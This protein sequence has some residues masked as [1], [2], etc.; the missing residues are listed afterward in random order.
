MIQIVHVH[1]LII[2]NTLLYVLYL[3]CLRSESYAYILHNSNTKNFF[4]ILD[5]RN[6]II[7]KKKIFIYVINRKR[8]IRFSINEYFYEIINN[9]NIFTRK[10][11]LRVQFSE[12]L[13]L[14]YILKG[15][16]KTKDVSIIMK[17]SH[18]S[19]KDQSFW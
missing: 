14:D 17:K 4:P 1:L 13:I 6:L 12:N 15:K 2:F 10:I 18:Y 19:L 16:R 9:E 8:T 3:A 11:F 5:P 7:C